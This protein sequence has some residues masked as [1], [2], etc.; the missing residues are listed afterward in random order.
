[1]PFDA[2]TLTSSLAAYV[3]SDEGAAVAR[4]VLAHGGDQKPVVYGGGLSGAARLGA[5]TL[6]ARIVL[7]E[8]GN[9]PVEMGCECVAEICKN[10]AKVIVIG[11]Q[12]DLATYRRLCQAGA[13][14]YFSY[15]VT[16][17]DI[18]SACA[19]PAAQAPVE[20]VPAPTKAPSIAVV[21]ASGGVGASLLAQNLAVYGSAP[22]GMN[23]RVALLDAD[24]RFG[25]QAVDLDRDET[26]GLF[27]A[28]MA[29]DRIDTTFINATMDHVSDRLS[30]YS[31]QTGTGQDANPYEAGLPSLIAP[32]RAAFDAVIT[33]VPRGLLLER[34]EIAD[35][36]DVLVMV[37]PAGFSGVNAASRLIRRVSASSPDLRILPV[38]SE[39]RRD[40]GLSL[41][42]IKTTIGMDVI[43]TLPRCDAVMARAHRAALPVVSYQRRGAYAK[44]IAQIWKAATAKPKPEAP[45]NRSVL[46]RIFK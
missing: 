7:A 17:E 1:M 32:L 3:C 30:L 19:E 2:S 24:V 40:A 18:L 9:I 38:M 6:H 46:K 35:Q 25:T 4:S 31:N 10:G 16:A 21:G 22:K 45:A 43:A 37:V 11:A 12:T 29:P 42:D 5:D 34:S 41:K 36:I 26:S 44:S 23:R 28:L 15:P 20:A 27:E 33:D 8:I 13:T 39:V 14:E